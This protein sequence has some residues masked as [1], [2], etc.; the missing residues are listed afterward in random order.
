M[1]MARRESQSGYILKVESSGGNQMGHAR[2]RGV[3]KGNSA[4]FGL[5]SNTNGISIH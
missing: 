4:V 5:T 1:E 2:G 3:I